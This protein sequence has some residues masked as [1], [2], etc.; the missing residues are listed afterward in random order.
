[1]GVEHSGLPGLM[2]A[3]RDGCQLAGWVLTHHVRSMV[4]ELIDDI[5]P[6]FRV[7]EGIGQDLWAICWCR[8]AVW[9]GRGGDVLDR[10][11]RAVVRE[12]TAQW[13]AAPLLL[14][15]GVEQLAAPASRAPEELLREARRRG[16]L[17]SDQCRLLVEVD[18]MGLSCSELARRDGVDEVGLRR[19]RRR[20]L[21]ALARDPAV[22]A[23]GSWLAV[24]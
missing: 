6:R 8:L 7:D 2:D 4:L 23:A 3:M 5:S 1:M 14:G 10:V 24:N 19:Q 17:R 20:A 12:L 21:A 11:A 22:R 9:P 13:Q 18:I 16:T 15:A